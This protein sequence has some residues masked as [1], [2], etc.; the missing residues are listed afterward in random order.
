M[1]TLTTSSRQQTRSPLDLA[2]RHALRFLDGLDDR[3]AGAPAD[4]ETLRRGFLRSLPD[5]GCDPAEVI[6][7][8]VAAAEPGLHG[9]AGGRFF[10]WVVGGALPAALAAGASVAFVTGCQMAHVTGLMTARH[11]LLRRLGWDVERDGLAGAPRI[12]ILASDQHHA[13]V[14]RA[15]RFIGLGSAS[16]VNLPTGEDCRMPAE[17]LARALAEDAGPTIVALQAGD[18]NTGAFDDFETLIPLIH[19]AGAWAHVDGAF[20]LWATASPQFR[21]LT[22]GIE[23]ADSWATDGHK[24]L[25]VP[26]DSG[27]AFTAHPDAHRASMTQHASYMETASARDQLDWNPEFSRRARGFAIY[28]ALRELGRQGLADLIERTCGF[29]RALTRRIG[30]LPG[31]E[32]LHDPVINQGLVRFLDPSPGASE[33]DHDRRTD[34]VISAIQRSGEAFF[35]GVTWHGRRAMRISVCNWRTSEADIERTVEAVRAA[36]ETVSSD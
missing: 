1:T 34:E 2:H 20:G 25:N 26:Y 6:D 35:G 22:R 15:A 13:S 16:I 30:D 4:A 11:E 7:D 18:L 21:H 14:D 12:R 3:P 5:E 9:S 23:A 31:A 36:L 10:G 17:A 29:C 33:A 8:L 24:W 32:R 28:A 27:L 19:E